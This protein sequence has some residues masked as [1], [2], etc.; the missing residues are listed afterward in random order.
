VDD[1]TGESWASSPSV[2]ANMQANRWRDTKPE[3]ALRSELFRRGLRYRVNHKPI[4]SLRRTADIVFRAAKVAVFVDGCFWHGCEQHHTVSKTN[5]TYWSEKIEENRARDADTNERLIAEGWLPI[6][7][8]EHEPV[9]AAADQIATA[10][11]ERVIGISRD[12]T[13]TAPSRSR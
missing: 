9:D 2:R 11:R 1:R 7:V 8:W 13:A 10:V 3:L 12:R 4:P 6:R 5:P